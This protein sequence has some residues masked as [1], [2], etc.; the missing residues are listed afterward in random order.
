MAQISGFTY[1]PPSLLDTKSGFFLPLT[2]T[3]GWATW[4]RVWEICDFECNDYK[5]L[6]HDKKL[7]Y[8]FNYN[9]SYNFKKMFIQ[10][11]ESNK[12]SSWGIRFYWNIFKQQSVV[13]YP[14]KSLVKN[15]GWDRSG[16][17]NDRYEIYPIMGW[18]P[19]YKVKN[20]PINSKL[21]IKIEKEIQSY[22]KKRT[23]F[24]LKL[25]HLI[26]EFLNL[27]NKI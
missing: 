24:F 22:I 1:A 16:K 27:K 26:M 13:L 23:S 20:Y 21:D 17:H 7:A 10:E 12:V 25:V 2:S 18:N 8:Q 5:L 11:M 6:K 19:E 15:I 4:K 3:W 9:N 14:E